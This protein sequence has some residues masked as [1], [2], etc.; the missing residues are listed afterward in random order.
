M[1]FLAVVFLATVFFAVAFLAVAFLAVV[2][3]LTPLEVLAI[4]TKLA[5]RREAVFFLMRPFLAALSYSDWALE[6]FSAVGLALKALRAFLMNFL[7]C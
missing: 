2:S 7:I 6:R 5:L 4:F 1:V 3:A